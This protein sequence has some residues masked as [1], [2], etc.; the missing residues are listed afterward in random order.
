MTTESAA[1]PPQPESTWAVVFDGKG[2]AQQPP[3]SMEGGTPAM[4]PPTWLHIPAGDSA[5]SLL[6]QLGELPPRVVEHF[7]R[8]SEQARLIT[9]GDGLLMSLRGVELSPGAGTHS[10]ALPL[11][12][13]W[14]RHDCLVTAASPPPAAI[15]EIHS[16]LMAGVGPD[17]PTD[18]LGRLALLL[19][20]DLGPLLD[21]Q[22]EALD[23]L[24][25]RV[26]TRK[27][28][29]LGRELNRIRLSLLRLD[30]RLSPQRTLL[31]DLLQ[32]QGRYQLG[33]EETREALR[34]ASE[35]VDHL[36]D[37]LDGL[38][39][40]CNALQGANVDLQSQQMNIALYLLSI[41]TA[42][43][44]PMGVLTGLLGINLGGIPGA[45]NPWGFWV[46]CL[47]LVLLGAVGY[48]VF[49]RIGLTQPVTRKGAKALLRVKK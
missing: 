7:T 17:G 8:P 19:I 21:D 33:T 30:R 20:R 15:R 3:S 2:G 41:Y 40:H 31:H 5:S 49:R 27:L 39:E 23:H 18:L 9:L 28:D 44:L 25:T 11:I 42:L 16:D 32:L 35:R 36:L 13:V 1:V 38:H 12:Q 34:E 43:F 26:L 4:G 37:R 24:E 46:A 45:H 47:L 22:I 48:L 14:I 6:L 10:V 29:H